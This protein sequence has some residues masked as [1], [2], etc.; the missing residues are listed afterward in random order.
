MTISYMKESDFI[1]KFKTDQKEDI[2]E[3]SEVSQDKLPLMPDKSA[4]M[5]H[6]NFYPEPK[7]Y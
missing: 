7:E 1:E 6:H 3:I 5:F 4:F 2:G